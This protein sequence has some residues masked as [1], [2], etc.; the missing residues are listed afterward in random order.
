MNTVV[1]CVFVVSVGMIV[2]SVDGSIEDVAGEAV[3]FV[4]VVEDAAVG[5]YVVSMA[6]VG[7]AEVGM[8]VISVVGSVDSVVGGAVVCMAV[9]GTNVVGEAVF[10]VAVL[11]G[12][13]VG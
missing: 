3:V 10:D 11:V 4:T 12:K 8:I 13:G 1:P 9:V 5:M 6:L 2:V 7:E